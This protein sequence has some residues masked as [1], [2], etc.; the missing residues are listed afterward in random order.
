MSGFCR[1]LLDTCSA[2]EDHGLCP[3]PG[4]ARPSASTSQVKSLPST[5]TWTKLRRRAT[6]GLLQEVA[7]IVGQ[8]LQH[9]CSLPWKRVRGLRASAWRLTVKRT[10]KLYEKASPNG[11]PSAPPVHCAQAVAPNGTA[12]LTKQRLR[13]AA[14]TPTLS[15]SRL[16]AAGGKALGPVTN[17]NDA[18]LTDNTWFAAEAGIAGPTSPGRQWARDK[19]G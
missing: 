10:S 1:A 8:L 19:S 15:P 3:V 14:S 7:I 11:N 6:R 12:V 4:N 5:K 16:V 2:Q 13:P 9:R 18:L 17:M